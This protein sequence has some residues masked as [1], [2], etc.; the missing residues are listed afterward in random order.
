[1]LKKLINVD[2][3]VYRPSIP[4]LVY[5]YSFFA[6][7]ADEQLDKV[8]EEIGFW[9]FKCH[10]YQFSSFLLIRVGM[11]NSL[12]ST[13]PLS[14]QHHHHYYGQSHV[15]TRSW[16]HLS[17]RIDCNLQAA[18]WPIFELTGVE[19]SATMV[20]RVTV[21]IWCL[22]M[23]ICLRCAWIACLILCISWPNTDLV[24]STSQKY[25]HLSF[26]GWRSWTLSN[27][28]PSSDFNQSAAGLEGVAMS[29]SIEYHSIAASFLLLGPISCCQSGLLSSIFTPCL[30]NL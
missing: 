11:S 12:S 9:S 25:C 29:G 28:E 26:F 16:L 22:Q 30:W 13:H 3:K 27:R 20:L 21:R 10:S 7:Y 5:Q 8:N 18:T 23:P 14:T 2:K 1:M 24:D 15:A 19:V 17:T 4:H 6:N